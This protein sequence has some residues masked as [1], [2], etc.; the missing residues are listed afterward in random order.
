MQNPDFDALAALFYDTVR[1]INANDYTK[2]QIELW[3]SCDKDSAFWRENLKDSTIFVATQNGTLVGFAD[4]TSEGFIGH[5]YV[6]KDHQHRGIGKQLLFAI[7]SDA[8]TTLTLE[9][10]ITS[11]PFFEK[12]GYRVQYAQM[13]LYRG[14][15]YFK[16]YLM[17]K[18]AQIS[19]GHP[20]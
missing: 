18:S 2:E 14:T 17:K 19:H 11:K 6:H 3:A 8:N 12:M 13:K 9:A 1:E 10:S 7:E 4:L 5:L 16:N 15:L 20:R